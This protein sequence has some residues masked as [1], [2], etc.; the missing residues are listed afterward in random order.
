MHYFL[1]ASLMPFAE[2]FCYLDVLYYC[3]FNACI[4]CLSYI[5]IETRKMTEFVIL[6][7]MGVW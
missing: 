6:L 5:M 2:Y 7:K 3:I 4:L 1:Q